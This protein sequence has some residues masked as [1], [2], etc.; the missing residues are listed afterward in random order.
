MAQQI[1]DLSDIIQTPMSPELRESLIPHGYLRDVQPGDVLFEAGVVHDTFFAIVDAE[2]QII[3]RTANDAVNFTLGAN[4]FLGELSLLQKQAASLAA[5]VSRPGHVLCV[6]LP[7][8]RRVI[9]TVPEVSDLVVSVFAARRRNLMQHAIGAL[10][11]IGDDTDPLTL[12]ALEYASRNYIPHRH[13]PAAS[14]EAQRLR[15][16]HGAG[17]HTTTV[18]T[19]ANTVLSEPTPRDIANAMG[20]DLEVCPKYPY[21]LAIVG[22]GPGGIAAAVYGASEGLRTVVVED[23]AIG[24]Q[25]GTSSR[26]ENYMGFPTGISGG[27]LCWRGEIQAIKFGAQFAMPRRAVGLKQVDSMHALELNDGTCLMCRAIVVACGV[28]YRRL[29][30]P[31]LEDFEGSGIYYAAT[32]LEARFCHDT[33]VVVIGGGNS[34]GQAAMF[35]S[36]TAEHVH[37]IVRGPSLAA[38]MS[39]YLTTRLNTDPRVTIHTE[40]EVTA[41]HGEASLRAVTLTN[42]DGDG[43]QHIVEQATRAVFVMIGA[44]PNTSWVG[45]CVALDDAGYILTGDRAGHQDLPF[46]TTC[47]GVFAIGDVRAGSVKRVASSVGEGSVVISAVH[48]FLTGLENQAG[49]AAEPATDSVT[50]GARSAAE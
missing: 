39:D 24:G 50:P 31:R 43:T 37:L 46:A 14:G 47:P 28:Q 22:G 9:A 26:I 41:L 40:C 38:T 44:A 18:I 20:A 21:D 33:H 3:D 2:V 1:E 30:L 34:A 13:L 48:T 4:Q 36:R 16:Q 49:T 29:P 6:P 15:A 23:T 10:T 12:R 8:L 27:D 42:R 25:A 35:L 11:I 5:V 45:D 7:A 32:D 19:G 17:D